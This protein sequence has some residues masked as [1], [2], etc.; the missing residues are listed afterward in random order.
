MSSASHSRYVFKDFVFDPVRLALYHN[1][2][3]V[4]IEPKSL[5]VLSVLLRTPRA[6]VSSQ[7]IIDEVWSDAPAGVTPVHLA[8]YIKKLRHAFKE[9]DPETEYIRTA[10]SLGYLFVVDVEMKDEQRTEP[11]SIASEPTGTVNNTFGRPPPELTPATAKKFPSKRVFA[12]VTLVFLALVF[13]VVIWK[14]EG[15]P[16]DEESEIKRVV[17]ESQLYESLD[18]YRDPKG[19]K[20]VELDKYWTPELDLTASYDRRQIRADVNNL[21]E[22][23]LHYGNESKCE[24][25]YFQSV[26]IDVSRKTAVVK[27]LEK[28][29]LAI[30]QDD[31]KLKQNKTVGPYF[32]SYILKKVDGRWLIEK[33][34]TARANPPAPVLTAIEPVSH[35]TSGQEFFV[36][37]TGSSFSP[38]VI[39]LKVIGPGCPDTDPCT[40]PNSALRMHS[41]LAETELNNVPLTLSSGEFT[42]FVQNG[43]S[44]PSNSLTLTVP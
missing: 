29:F 3:L 14:L 43:E 42:I 11:Q 6:L 16:R 9:F 13:S 37:L 36:K 21:I 34:S 19:F 44:K 15:S 28:W 22:K 10:K 1:G 39:Y 41:D 20:E 40:V 17:K 2:E 12:I 38:Q 4:G 33:S 25:F 5:E 32:V 27:T 7:E 30:Y 31:G 24:Q 26:G 23:G 35:I 18:L 8:Q